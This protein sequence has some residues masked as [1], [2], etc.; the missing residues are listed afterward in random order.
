MAHAIPEPIQLTNQYNKPIRPRRANKH[1]H[2]FDSRDASAWVWEKKRG[3][4]GGEVLDKPIQIY[5]M[6]YRFLQLALELEAQKVHIITKHERVPLKKPKK[7]EWG[8]LRKSVVR[9]IKHK[10]KVN[11]KKYSKWN[12]DI[13]P[14]TSFNDWWA[15][16]GTTAHR[17]LFYADKGAVLLKNQ[18]EWIEDN[19][20]QYLK[21][22]KRARMNDV[23]RDIRII[24]AS[25]ERNPETV[26]D[27]PINGMPNISTLVNRYNALVLKISTTDTDE[28][29]FTSG[30]FRST[31]IGMKGT[32]VGEVNP[33][34][35]DKDAGVLEKKISEYAIADKSWGRTM[36][37]LILPAKVTLLSVCDG[38]FISNPNK[39]YL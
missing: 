19:N 9:P 36:R 6:W 28:K 11:R 38:Y 22:D 27:F 34:A 12:L 14:T 32:I 24:F 16:I 10:V 35:F 29:I 30:I 3:G 7:D 20:Y 25:D 13:I 15:G 5:R 21:I 8:H 37:D 18:D 31:Q 17:E 23:V 2:T 39:D 33:A 4:T 26:S 1:G